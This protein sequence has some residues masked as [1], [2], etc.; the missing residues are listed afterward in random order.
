MIGIVAGC[1]LI[2]FGLGYALRGVIT[3][4]RRRREIQERI[5]L[6]VDQHRRVGQA[7]G[8]GERR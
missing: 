1:T 8:P 4:W 6:A 3:R 2:G 7:L 5:L